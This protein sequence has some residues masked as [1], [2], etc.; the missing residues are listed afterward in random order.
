MLSEIDFLNSNPKALA[1]QI[2]INAKTRRLELNLTQEELAQKSGVSLGSV[3]RFESKHEIS[4]KHLL[5]IAVVLNSTEDFKNLFLQKQY[6]SIDE[7]V[8][9]KEMKRKRARRK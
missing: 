3:K 5:L 8:V 4:L 1:L 2:V 7:V 9:K 6:R